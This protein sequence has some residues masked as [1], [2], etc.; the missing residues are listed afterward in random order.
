MEGRIVA[1]ELEER[2]AAA[3]RARTYGDLDA[4]VS[5]LPGERV[6]KRPTRSRELLT[7]HPLA[8]VVA[9]A[10]IAVMAFA[11]AALV[12]AAFSG[13]WIVLVVF[14]V[15]HRGGT[16]ARR[17]PSGR[18]AQGSRSARWVR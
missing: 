15:L 12:L 4:V 2:V 1:H 16:N 17:G 8:L 11:L 5:D 13:I 14:A 9:V 7:G 3:L 10:V 18:G 6:A